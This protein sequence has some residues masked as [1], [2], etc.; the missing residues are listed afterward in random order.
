[1]TTRIT[2]AFRDQATSC[3]ALGSPFTAQLCWVIGERLEA[4]TPLADLLLAWPGDITS[5]GQSVPLRVAGALHALRLLGRAGLATV[6]PPNTVDD[7]ALWKA[8]RQAMLDEGNFIAASIK[9]PPQTNEVRRAAAL[10]GAAHWLSERFGLPLALSELGAS[11]GLNLNFDRFALLAHDT[12]FGAETSPVQ[13]TPEWRGVLPPSMPFSVVDRRG[14]D[15]NPLDPTTPEGR[16]RLIA[17]LWADQPHRLTLTRAAMSL[18]ETAPD[19][20]DGIDWLE[21]RL[22]TGPMRGACHMIYTTVA[23]QYFPREAQDRGAALIAAAGAEAT[24]D[25][26]LARI[27]MEADAKGPG[28]AL[29][30]T[31]WPSGETYDLGRAD[32]HG[33]WIDWS[34]TKRGSM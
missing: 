4:G 33:R 23:W 15:L 24:P 19:R 21:K 7:D 1:M 31:V 32:F 25:A 10:I 22:A 29:T 20:G 16:L 26:P 5:R 2:A 8:V 28:A 13:L 9:L 34:P 14:V 3:A 17:F 18:A 27:A 11:G 12:H 6:Y 30:A